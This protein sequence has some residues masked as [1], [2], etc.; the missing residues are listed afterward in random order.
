MQNTWIYTESGFRMA[1]TAEVATSETGR[2]RL[3]ESYEG[4]RWEPFYTYEAEEIKPQT[5]KS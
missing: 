4:G 2:M 3:C 1:R 5:S